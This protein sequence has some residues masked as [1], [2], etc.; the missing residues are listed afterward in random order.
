MSTTE[1]VNRMGNNSIGNPIKIKGPG[2]ASLK[3]RI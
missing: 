3:G 2:E 1:E